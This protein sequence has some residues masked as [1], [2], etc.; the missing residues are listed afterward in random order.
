MFML[1]SKKKKSAVV[2]DP[3]LNFYFLFPFCPLDFFDSVPLLR[4]TREE[5]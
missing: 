1:I 4:S 2:T 5:F 3:P